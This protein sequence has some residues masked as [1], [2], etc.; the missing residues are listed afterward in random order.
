MTEPEELREYNVLL[1]GVATT[2]QLTPSDFER[3][4][5]VAADNPDEP[6]TQRPQEAD[7][8]VVNASKA[9][10]VENKAR[11]SAPHTEQ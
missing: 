1:N 6:A 10:G 5:W 9:R 11:K 3:Q 4:G 2:M 7:S 8:N